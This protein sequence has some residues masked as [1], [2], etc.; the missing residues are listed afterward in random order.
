M[1]IASW[2]TIAVL[3]LAEAAAGGTGAVKGRV[4]SEGSAATPV[5]NAVVLIEG[6]QT[7][8]SPGAPHATIDQRNVTFVPHVLAVPVGTTV[9]FPNHDSTLH[10]VFSASAAKKFD[11]GMYD[12][13]ESRSVTFDVPGIIRIG[14]NAHAKMEAFVVV[15][16]NPYAAVTDAQGAYTV[17]Q[18]PPA[19]YRVRVWHESM[20]EAETRVDVHDGQVE[21]VD[22]RLQPRR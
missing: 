3:T 21:H 10:N 1:R 18:V 13:G 2:V 6:P 17:D 5:A 19:S 16:T 8:A 11:L 9:D 4:T 7:P 12:R 22:L 15:H 14:C 20:P